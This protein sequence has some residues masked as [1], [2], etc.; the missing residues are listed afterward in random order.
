MSDHQL[1]AVPEPGADLEYDLAH[2]ASGASA[3][4]GHEAEQSGQ[5]VVTATP[6]YEADSPLELAREASSSRSLCSPPLYASPSGGSVKE[7]ALPGTDLAV[8]DLLGWPECH[9]GG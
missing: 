4:V 1:D 6:A 5:A 3:T 7:V 9:P 2:E 8:W